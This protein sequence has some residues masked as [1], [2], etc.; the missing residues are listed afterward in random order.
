MSKKIK[1]LVEVDEENYQLIK[2][3]ADVAGMSFCEILRNGTPYNPTDDLISRSE[4][5]S[6][7]FLSPQVKV[8]G[9]RHNGKTKEQIVE[10]YQKGWNDCIDAITDNAPT[11]NIKDQIAGA[12]NEGYMCGNKEAEKARPQGEWYYSIDKG[13]ECNQCHEI[14]KDMPTCMRKAL[15]NFC[16]NCGADMRGGAE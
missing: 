11:V 7:K 1:L 3:M 15:Y 13:W 4:L 12:Y 14:V 2:E 9:S 8:V 10:A 16:P 5:K 6:H